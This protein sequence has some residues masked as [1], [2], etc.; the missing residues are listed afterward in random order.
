[1]RIAIAAAKPD[2]K[3]DVGR[4]GARMPYY[5]VFDESAAVAEILPNPFAAYDR[6]AGLRVADYL[7]EN[8]IDIVVAANF[9]TGFMNALESKGIRY[10]AYEGAILDAARKIATGSED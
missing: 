5:I 10:M 7:H 3:G 6:A 1:M 9:G 2:A 4:R 8:R